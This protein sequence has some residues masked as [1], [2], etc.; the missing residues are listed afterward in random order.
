M[1]RELS[2]VQAVVN[3]SP[4]QGTL[5]LPEFLDSLLRVGPLG[6]GGRVVLPKKYLESSFDLPG[7]LSMGKRERGTLLL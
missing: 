7:K 2:T 4:S 6:K 3:P 1:K 5:I